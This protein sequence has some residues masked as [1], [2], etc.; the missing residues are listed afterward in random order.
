MAIAVLVVMPCAHAAPPKTWSRI[1]GNFCIEGIPDTAK[2]IEQAEES[3]G[4]VIE[5]FDIDYKADASSYPAMMRVF[6]EQPKASNVLTS[7]SQLRG[8]VVLQGRIKVLWIRRARATVSSTPSYFEVGRVPGSELKA[9]LTRVD[10]SLAPLYGGNLQLGGQ[11]GIGNSRRAWLRNVGVIQASTGAESMG[12]LDIETWGRHLSGAKLQLPGNDETHTVN[13]SAGNANIVI[14]SQ[15]DGSA[16]ELIHGALRGGPFT[17]QLDALSLP[18]ANLKGVALKAET[19]VLSADELG[20]S[21]HMTNLRYTAEGGLLGSPDT[22]ARLS[23]VAGTGARLSSSLRQGAEY[24]AFTDPELFAHAARGRD[25]A[26]AYSRVDLTAA[27][28]CVVQTEY[29]NR[30]GFAM[31]FLAHGPAS[32]VAKEAFAAA[33][34]VRWSLSN[35]DSLDTLSGSFE[36][37]RATLGALQLDAGRVDFVQPFKNGPVLEI[38]FSVSIGPA[39]GSWDLR[40]EP[41]RAVIKGQLD[42]LLLRGTVGIPLETPDDW[43]IR[44][45]QDDFRFGGGVAAELQPH[46]YGGTPLLAVGTQLAFRSDS[47]VAVTRQQARGS[48]YTRV[49]A[50]GL[51]NMDIE[52]GEGAEALVVEGPLKFEAGVELGYLLDNGTASIRSGKVDAQHLHVRTKPNQVGDFGP[53]RVQDAD[54]QVARIAAEFRPAQ[55]AGT[56]EVNDVQL[57]VGAIEQKPDVGADQFRWAGDL[58]GPFTVKALHAKLAPDQP[59]GALKLREVS[60]ENVSLT[61]AQPRVGQDDALNFRGRS[62][63]LAFD[64]ISEAEVRGKFDMADASIVANVDKGDIHLRDADLALILT[65]GPLNSPNGHGRLATRA[66]DVRLDADMEIKE[67]CEGEP[68]YRSLPI[69]IDFHIESLDM[70]LAIQAGRLNGR[71]EAGVSHSLIKNTG[72][73]DCPK[74][75]VDWPIVKEVR[76]KFKYPCPTWRKPLRMCDGWTTVI[77]EVRVGVDREFKIRHLYAAGIFREIGMEISSDGESATKFKRC[78][79]SGIFVPLI[80]VSYYVRPRTS[81]RV[82]DEIID[83]MTDAFARPLTTALVSGITGTISNTLMNEPLTR[84]FLG[85]LCI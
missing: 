21:L 2:K 10:S 50:F 26:Y 68:H 69:Q 77:P 9:E 18:T 14:R 51:S 79:R 64:L 54:F 61:L 24:L 75:I 62:L 1:V 83:E 60:L 46:I 39:S 85:G 36:R 56:L 47:D 44:I 20:A 41:G 3:N 28:T 49:S 55:E 8:E 42:E 16:T 53:V 31:E 7:C 11:G 73:Y 67:A 34:E 38:P 81:L 19:L 58:V 48:V 72:T 15:L 30:D 76:A 22:V 37:P 13:L 25:C 40:A 70:A 27:N 71:G 78:F 65:G 84:S 35:A 29:A 12:A 82:A 6:R 59:G 33:G 66:A 80:D 43:I 4:V 57:A 23:Q 5:Q 52:L 74:Q 63:S 17:F 32:T 45:R